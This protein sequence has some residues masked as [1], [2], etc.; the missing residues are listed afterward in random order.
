MF[1]NFTA[2]LSRDARACDLEGQM[3][4]CME[5]SNLFNRR[6]GGFTAVLATGAIFT[7][8]TCLMHQT[9]KNQT[10]KKLSL[11]KVL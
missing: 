2:Q 6:E 9:F 7:V 8:R 5:S 11:K 10:F 3:R 4:K 1:K